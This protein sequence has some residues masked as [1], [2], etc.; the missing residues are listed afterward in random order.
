MPNIIHATL[1][2]RIHHAKHSMRPW[3]VE[4]LRAATSK[5]SSVT[6]A[7]DAAATTPTAL[8]SL[9]AFHLL[10]SQRPAVPPPAAEVPADRGT[11]AA[12]PRASVTSP[13]SPGAPVGTPGMCS[14]ADS[15]TLPPRSGSGSGLGPIGNAASARYRWSDSRACLPGLPGLPL[16]RATPP[17]LGFRAD[18]CCGRCVAS[19]L[20]RGQGRASGA[21]PGAEGGADPAGVP[22]CGRGRP[23]RHHAISTCREPALTTMCRP[24]CVGDTAWLIQLMQ[25]QRR[26]YSIRLRSS[27]WL[28]ENPINSGAM[29]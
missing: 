5:Q 21:Q 22:G 9:S 26:P 29:R 13:G 7:S 24:A 19:Q 14:G 20:W 23:S 2:L 1:L 11:A 6:E 18:P 3:K 28:A 17:C 4:H 8:P 10:A 16:R 27:K 25:L 15:P 12:S